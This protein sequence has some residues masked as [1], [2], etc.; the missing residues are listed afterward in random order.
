ML[1]DD[2][3]ILGAR[4][5]EASLFDIHRYWRFYRVYDSPYLPGR[6]HVGG[7]SQRKL[8]NARIHIPVTPG[9]WILVFGSLQYDH[10]PTCWPPR[11]RCGTRSMQRR[12]HN[13]IPNHYPFQC[14]TH[15]LN[16]LLCADVGHGHVQAA[17]NGGRTVVPCMLALVPSHPPAHV[18]EPK[19][20]VSA[21]SCRSC[22]GRRPHYRLGSTDKGRLPPRGVCLDSCQ[23]KDPNT[24]PTCT[25]PPF[26]TAL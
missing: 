18:G 4:G 17:R 8:P 19:Q 13:D 11:M 5:A 16:M 2:T 3:T 21:S 14:R 6:H 9:L 15:A 24:N 20:L 23:T 7:R 10:F 25:S 22:C 1:S 26:R 12:T